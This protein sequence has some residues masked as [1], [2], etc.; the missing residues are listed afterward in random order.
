MRSVNS[1]LGQNWPYEVQ[2]EFSMVLVPLPPLIYYKP[3]LA[4]GDR[5]LLLPEL[6]NFWPIGIS[7]GR[8]CP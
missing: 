6:P 8:D 3:R 5:C 1:M 4:I 7:S 2:A